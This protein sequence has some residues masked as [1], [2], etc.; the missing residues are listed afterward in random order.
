VRAG[1]FEGIETESSKGKADT[2]GKKTSRRRFLAGSVAAAAT[3]QIAPR[4]ILG[5][6]AS[7]DV[8]RADKMAL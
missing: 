5:Q 3:V 8:S 1:R 2:S 4:H 6:R 7:A